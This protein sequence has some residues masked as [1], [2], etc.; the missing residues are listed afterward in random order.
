MKGP[1]VGALHGSASCGHPTIETPSGGPAGR[2]ASRTLLAIMWYQGLAT[3]LLAIT[4]PWIAVR[5]ALDAVALARLYALMSLSALLTF[6]AARLAD[7]IGRRSLLLICLTAT[8]V[9][10]VAAAL[11]G[12]IV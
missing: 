3:P 8:S 7:R 9:M 1:A 12:S 11:S 10:A 5:F 2:A 4:A 6:G